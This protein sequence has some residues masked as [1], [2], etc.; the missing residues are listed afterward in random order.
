E[1]DTEPEA[2]A[3]EQP[4]AEQPEEPE[5][6]GETDIEDQTEDEPVAAE[7]TADSEAEA[8]AEEQPAAEQPEE[9]S[10]QTSRHSETASEKNRVVLKLAKS[11]SDDY[12]DL[13]GPYGSDDSGKEE[14]E[15]TDEP[16]AE[17]DNTPVKGFS[18]EAEGSSQSAGG[19]AQKQETNSGTE[20]ADGQKAGAGKTPDTK[21]KTGSGQNQ[22]E[23]LSK[24]LTKKADLLQKMNRHEEAIGAFDQIIEFCKGSGKASALPL[25]S[26][27]YFR[28]AETLEKTDKPDRA[29]TAYD[30]FIKLADKMNRS[31][32]GDSSEAARSQV[33]FLSKAL[34]KKSELLQSLERNDEAVSALDQIIEFCKAN[35]SDDNLEVLSQTYF[36]KAEI[37]EKLQ[38]FD[39][40]L[41]AY[42][43]F[44]S[45]ISAKESSA[46]QDQVKSASNY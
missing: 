16:L 17:S 39:E 10:P 40:A 46:N 42:N 33:E 26:Q 24:A 35:E 43:E 41:L 13:K 7:Q 36:I 34:I 6:A 20:T 3:E 31:E 28:K 44:I 11:G 29:L 5:A 22:Y 9:S 25:L 45:A 14:D 8:E 12:S 38:Q 27:T 32:E 19:D 23:F 1:E 2:E 37:L 18:I 30:E 21:A 15:R 4:A